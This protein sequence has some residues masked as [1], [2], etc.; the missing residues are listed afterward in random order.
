[1]T[2]MDITFCGN[3]ENCPRR[4]GCFRCIDNLQI[5]GKVT[6][7]VADF[8]SAECGSDCKFFIPLTESYD[9]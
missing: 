1:M 7:S 4:D 9:V 2:Y 6:L 5:S 3:N 8:F